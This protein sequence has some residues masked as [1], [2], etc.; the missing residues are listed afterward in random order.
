[1]VYRLMITTLAVG[2]AFAAFGMAE[3]TFKHYYKKYADFEDMKH[4]GVQEVTFVGDHEV[5]E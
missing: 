1:M 5:M 3:S 4:T 2:A